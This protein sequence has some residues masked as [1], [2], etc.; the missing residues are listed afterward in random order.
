MAT[1]SSIFV[2]AGGSTAS[3]ATAD[4][5]GTI[6]AGTSSAEIILSRYQIFAINANG[7][8]N[9]RFGNSG[10][11]AAAN[12]DFR[13]PGGLVATYQIPAQY[14]RFRL[15]NNGSGSVTYW[16]QPLVKTI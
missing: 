11:P 4:L 5:N 16:I 14:D 15:F 9:I 13:I 12:T 7:D 6:T 10:M 3:A 8:V 1:L 2:P